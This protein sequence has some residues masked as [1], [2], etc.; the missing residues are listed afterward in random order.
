MKKSPT[1]R[2][3]QILVT[4]EEAG[5]IIG[6]AKGEHRSVSS[7]GRRVLVAAVGLGVEGGPVAKP[8]RMK[9]KKHP[10]VGSPTQ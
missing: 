6:A 1:T 4:V 5:A 3:I 10:D 2:N 8:S 9:E 7:W